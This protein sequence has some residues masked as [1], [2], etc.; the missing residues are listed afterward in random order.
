MAILQDFK[1]L[2]RNCEPLSIMQLVPNFHLHVSLSETPTA[3]FSC[4]R[5]LIM[6]TTALVWGFPT[7]AR[8]FILASWLML[9]TTHL[10]EDLCRS[11]MV[12]FWHSEKI[13]VI[14]DMTL[15]TLA[16]CHGPLNMTAAG[17]SETW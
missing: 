5:E 10:F 12:N 6:S 7:K 4:Y 11:G 1:S 15:C 2:S 13:N 3:V 17:S 14:W 9:S 16:P 8:V